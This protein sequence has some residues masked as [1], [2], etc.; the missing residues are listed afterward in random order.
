[1]KRSVPIVAGL[2]LLA[3][4]PA[5]ERE[6]PPAATPDPAPAT[7]RTPTEAPASPVEARPAADTGP[8]VVAAGLRFPVPEGWRTV[9]P[10]NPMRL[11]EVQVPGPS[12]GPDDT[13]TIAFSTAGGDVEGNIARWAGQMKDASG[14]P[15]APAVQRRTVDG[16]QVH[17]VE[18][19]GAYTGMG[20]AARADWTLRGAIIEAPAG[21]VFV[22][23]TG[24]AAPMSAAAAGF[25]S[26]I[27]GLKAQ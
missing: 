1:M 17:V 27:D 22:K 10:S 11:A 13:C 6:S 5:C 3:A 20:E 19:T 15:G 7:A 18:L 14:Q 12:G 21:L 8:A 9:P 24:P 25:A 26:M 4:V 16:L 23:M 2:V